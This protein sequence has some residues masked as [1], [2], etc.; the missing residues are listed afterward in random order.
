MEAIQQSDARRVAPEPELPEDRIWTA[1]TTDGKKWAAKRP[2][3]WGF[4]PILFGIRHGTEMLYYALAKHNKLPMPDGQILV[5]NGL[6]CWATDFIKSRT[7]LGEVDHPLPE[8]MQAKVEKTFHSDAAQREAYIR[9]LFLDVMLRN[10]DRK[11]GNILKVEVGESLSLFYF[12]HEQ[13]FG[14]RGNVQVFGR[15]RIKTPE[16]EYAEIDKNVSLEGK[17]HW[18]RTYSTF[19]ER[20]RIFESLD[21][22]ASMLDELEP[23]IPSI[24]GCFAQSDKW[25]Y[26]DQFID[27]KRGIA[28]W[29]EYMLN[30]PYSALD[31]RLF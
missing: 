6:S 12:D 25:I 1:E 10:F 15:N 27:M 22:Q 30:M 20:K 19:S 11:V 2:D 4:H 5:V 28:A 29:W 17:Y 14:W 24:G 8:P 23:Q 7:A 9:A 18:A 26:P 3:W 31:S 13:S 16:E 21:L